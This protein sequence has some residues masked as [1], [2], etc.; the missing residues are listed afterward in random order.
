MS[1]RSFLS[2]IWRHFQSEPDHKDSPAMND[3]AVSGLSETV[4]PPPVTS[5]SIQEHIPPYL[6]LDQKEALAH[7]LSRFPAD[8]EYYLLGKFQ[9]ELLQGDGWTKMQVLRFETGEKKEVLGIIFSNTCD[10]D[11]E[12]MRE[13]PTNIVFAPILKLSNYTRLLENAGLDAEKLKNKIASIK[14]QSVTTIFYL[15]DSVGSLS[16]EHIVL[17]D[18][19]HTMPSSAFKASTTKSKTFTLSNLGFYIFVFKLSMHFCRLRENVARA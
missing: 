7:A 4:T 12:N 15:P 18:D 8:S 2:H 19:V 14:S 16:E 5:Q 1:L 11:P 10:V 17:L 13:L 6:T 3:A 9:D